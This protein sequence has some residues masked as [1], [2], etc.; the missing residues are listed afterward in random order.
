M[1][2]ATRCMVLEQI[3]S[4]SAPAYSTRCLTQEVACLFPT[5]LVLQAFHLGKVHRIED[6]GG[7]MHAPQRS[8]TASLR[9][10]YYS[11]E[12]SQLN[13]PSNP[14]VFIDHVLSCA[15]DGCS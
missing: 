7:R 2:S 15:R 8:R 10:R 12:D 11:R 6:A 14:I 1:A 9:I 5:I 3:S 4:T 13:P